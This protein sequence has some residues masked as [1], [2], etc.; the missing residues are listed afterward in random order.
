MSPDSLDN[1]LEKKKGTK[2]ALCKKLSLSEDKPLLGVV[3]DK[4]L[5]PADEDRLR[6]ILEGVLHIDINIVVLTDTDVF[7]D[8]QVKHISYSRRGRRE[9]LEASDM[10]L[11]FPFSDIQ[12]M[13]LNGTVPIS[14][15]RPEISD[16][17]PNK[18]TGNGFVYKENDCWCMFAAIV[19]A[20][21]TFKFPYDWNNIVKQGLSSIS[22]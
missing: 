12:E 15:S 10:S 4:K 6:S 21:E 7:D 8:N 11:S 13:L 22:I 20:L 14:P 5:S 2:A 1:L 18:E 3:L 17:N 16:Y 19:R 9:L